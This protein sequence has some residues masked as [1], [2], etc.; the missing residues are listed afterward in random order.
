M[1]GTDFANNA[2]TRSQAPFESRASTRKSPIARIQA[3]ARS[4]PALVFRHL[5]A[6]T[7]RRTRNT[8]VICHPGNGS[9]MARVAGGIALALGLASVLH[10]RAEILV[11]ESF[12]YPSG[13]LVEVS[14]GRW[15]THSGTSG[16]VDV[17]DQALVLTQKETEDVHLPLPGAPF[18]TSNPTEL[19]ARAVVT[20]ETAPTGTQGAYF[21]HF[22]EGLSTFRGRLFISTNNVD[23]G[24]VRF[25]VAA[26][27]NQATTWWPEPSALS[28]PH[29]IVVRYRVDQPNLTL[30]LNPTTIESASITSTDTSTPTRISSFALRQAVSSGNGM[31]VLRLDDLRL[32]SSPN[33]VFETEHPLPPAI[34]ILRP[35]VSIAVEEGQTTEFKVDTEG[36]TPLHYQW[37]HNGV[38][39]V[40]ATHSTLVINSVT[41]F[42]AGSYQVRITDGKQEVT[43]EPATLTVIPALRVNSVTIADFR[44]RP[45]E[46]AS[47]IDLWC[48]E[49]WVTA[50]LTATDVSRTRF[51]LQDSTGGLLIDAETSALITTPRRGDALRITGSALLSQHAQA[52][53][54]VNLNSAGHR[55]ELSQLGKAP[56]PTTLIPQLVPG[57]TTH[58]LLEGCL[59]SMSNVFLAA[60]RESS[61]PWETVMVLDDQEE[62]FQLIL[63]PQVADLTRRALPSCPVNILGVLLPAAA[64]NPESPQRILITSAQDLETLPSVPQL[65]FVSTLHLIRAGDAI[66]N[67]FTEQSLRTGDVL[68]IE[69]RVEDPFGRPVEF[70]APLEGIPATARWRQEFLSPGVLRAQFHYKAIAIDAGKPF[71]I[72]GLAI[73]DDGTNR[74]EIELYLA[75]EHEQQIVITEFLANPTASTSS[76]LFNPLRR[77]TPASDPASQ[78][79]FVEIANLGSAPIDLLGWSLSDSDQKRHRFSSSTLLMP[80]QAL[81]VYGGPS[82]GNAP[83]L[84]NL[85]VP[86]SLGHGGLGLNN[87]GG[88]HIVLRNQGG[89][90][91]SRIVY[92]TADPKGSLA[93]YPGPDA[94]F[95]AHASVASAPCSPGLHTSGQTY[96]SVAAP[97]NHP[98]IHITLHRTDEEQ[99]QL[100]WHAT[101]GRT[102]TVWSAADISQTF[103]VAN[104]GLLF[105][106]TK[107]VWMIPANPRLP[108]EYFRVT[109]P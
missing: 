73:N 95:V 50:M 88:D 48:V 78:D 71:L 64:D 6:F 57:N 42:D 43:S 51:F 98:E 83:A 107:A 58:P 20:I 76:P 68:E 10:P 84:A 79:E 23:P 38:P 65:S 53:L 70:A 81:I 93:R 5:K 96:E 46:S 28:A 32:G 35:P 17:Q 91:V 90:I 69:L 59:V 85:C 87:Q 49:G 54:Q 15:L 40:T 92:Q 33:D 67:Q 19:W 100:A 26:A 24:Q 63:D 55:L 94:G 27:S 25:G 101:L 99:L 66:T 18:G 89:S 44:T 108:R 39:V 61:S 12:D 106:D 74:W 102:Y 3:M 7:S 80:H 45:A 30:W 52:S 103:K 31:G 29:T 9:R 109:T 56:A 4:A 37:L 34:H 105:L 104:S 62:R 11:D 60:D 14:S 2:S 21:A 75:S 86:A 36:P 41:P 47:S 8:A 16:Q 1:C 72:Q 82:F 77:Q 22:K 13:P 97:P